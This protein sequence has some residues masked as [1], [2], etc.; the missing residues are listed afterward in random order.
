VTLLERIILH[1]DLIMTIGCVK[2]GKFVTNPS[3]YVITAFQ[4]SACVAKCSGSFL[5]WGHEADFT[6]ADD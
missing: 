1:S 5:R 3:S 2:S 4:T 6:S